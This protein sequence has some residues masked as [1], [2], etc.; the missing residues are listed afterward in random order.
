MRI[1]EIELDN[2]KSFGEKTTIPIL[3]GFTA[4]SGPNGSGKSNVVDSLMFALGLTTT[5]N[6]RAEKL[7]DLINNIS[8]RNEC[9]VK[10]TFIQDA[11][12][13]E[14]SLL[15]KIKIKKDGY[16]SKYFLND[17]P[18][19]L[20]DIHDKLGKYNISP[21]GY[22]VVMQ[23]DVASI[24]SMNPVDRRKII[25]E[26]A[27]VAEFD[28]KIE[29]ADQ[30][31]TVVLERIEGQKTILA[32]LEDRLDKLSEQRA[33][34]LKYQ[35]LKQR[36]IELER[37][38]LAVRIRQ[39]RKDK[40]LTEQEAEELRVL[41]NNLQA[42]Q[43]AINEDMAKAQEELNRIT[44][45]IAELGEK[46]L[47]DLTSQREE[48][49]ELIAREESALEYIDQQIN[50]ETIEQQNLEKE[51]KDLQKSLKNIEFKAGE[52]AQEIESIRNNINEEEARYQ[53]I[54][55]QIL[56]KSKN[57]NISTQ[58]IIQSQDKVSE[59]KSK[60]SEIE[61]DK[62]RFDE[63]I[64]LLEEKLNEH[65]LSAERSLQKIQELKTSADT[66]ESI[67]TKEQI[68]FHS[69]NVQT[70]KEEQRETKEEIKKQEYRLKS[71]NSE[72]NKLEGQ[73]Q[74]AS[75]AGFGK[76]VE[77][78]LK[79]DGVH[80]TLAQLGRVEG[81]YQMAVETAAGARLRAVV[82]DDDYVAQECID[83]LRD[84]K[85]GR[86]TFL[87][88]NKMRESKSYPL[89]NEKGVIDWAI[90][91][92]TFDPQYQD[93]FGYAFADT[94]VVKNLEV[95]RKLIGR[96]RMVTIEG[97]QIERSGA[98]TGGAAVKSGIHFGA[99]SEKQKIRLEEQKEEV[100]RFIKQLTEEVENLEGQIEESRVQIEKYKEK[101]GDIQ[102][103][104]GISEAQIKTLQESYEQ[105]KNAISNCAGQIDKLAQDREK[106]VERI[107]KLDTEIDKES[108]GLQ[109][110]AA[111]MEDSKL[112][113]I[114]QESREIEVEIKRYQTMLNNVI[115]ESKSLEV[116]KNFS[117]QNIDKLKSKIEAS[118]QEIKVLQIR[119]PI[120]QSKIDNLKSELETI[121]QELEKLRA[122]LHSHHQKR[123]EISTK[124]ISL[125]QRKG[126]ISSSIEST[127]IKIVEQKKK[128]ISLN[129]HLS[130]LL[131]ELKEHPEL[132]ELELPEE[133]ITQLQ[134]ELS[135]IE[136]QMRSME[137]INMH[138]IHEYD[139][140]NARKEE[141]IGKQETLF[142]ERQ[143]LIDKIDSYKNEKKTAFLS[144]FNM[145]DNYFREI[146]AD[147]SFGQGELILEDPQEVFNGGLV[148]KAQ[149]RGKKMQ[150]LEAMSGGEKSLTA[151]SFLFA[152]QQCNPAPFYAFDE[153][154]SALDGVNV[155]RL[156]HKIRR[157]A[158]N[159]QFIVVSH[160]RPMLEQSD[161]A[162]G[163][164]VSKRGYS[165]VIGV[166]NIDHHDKELAAA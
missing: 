8:G 24:I 110:L 141:M 120:H 149:P 107:K 6:M 147:L 63:K 62:A 90:N 127:A 144:N 133:D 71:L 78:V 99:D 54:Q 1:K 92:V 115:N 76:A 103:Q 17:N 74:A 12:G 136:K 64:S 69:R 83:F 124:L 96:Y 111:E 33:Q 48:K 162:V 59:L 109:A 114:I 43:I 66:V 102:A 138:A 146:F 15:R 86:A 21:K 97:D 73:E 42:E 14:I 89:P 153:V 123:D 68:A 4:I 154:D 19:T 94:L 151:L 129:E 35:E 100:E 132:E 37:K 166:Q 84:A 45:E 160:R 101:L 108:I 27:G 31:L 140:V 137:P 60:K 143:M 159:T 26:I 28:R 81:E 18:S 128:L 164:S 65:R 3:D 5:R 16:D 104:S 47:Q 57:S 106:F 72:I 75:A 34:A 119:K 122:K 22:N 85:S 58:S 88:L 82:V 52:Y 38:F 55:Q 139:E 134:N 32:E 41:K 116:E 29:L 40:E 158:Q 7:T 46:Q 118:N 156:A 61:Q 49:K 30:E 11:T 155:D 91:L 20:R 117:S 2:F 131:E 126:E 67:D 161:R 121:D 80:G 142:A 23:G 152:L 51:I 70:L 148:I 9:S 44:Q 10:V 25:D 130:Q 56:A 163:V 95:A 112:E 125:G 13:E 98:M 77:S 39:V 150:R 36:R 145:I 50:N 87:P 157:N 53:A 135:K 93:A 79:I 113:S 165:Q 105:E